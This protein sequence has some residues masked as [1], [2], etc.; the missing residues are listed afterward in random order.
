MIP[1][2]LLLAWFRQLLSRSHA[3]NET[4][5]FWNYRIPNAAFMVNASIAYA[6]TMEYSGKDLFENSFRM[7]RLFFGFSRQY[8]IMRD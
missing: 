5:V 6:S 1:A 2:N 7:F 8:L 3:K 4:A